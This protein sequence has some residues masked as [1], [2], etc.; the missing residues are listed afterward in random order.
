MK[1]IK[2]AISNFLAVALLSAS[3]ANSVASQ[4]KQSSLITGLTDELVDDKTCQN[5]G[6]ILAYA[7]TKDYALY[8][9]ADLKDV[10]S[11]RYYRSVNKNGTSGVSL[12][13]KTY[14]P[15]QGN[16]FEFYNGDY[17]YLLQIPSKTIQDPV[18]MVEF[19]DGSG[20][21]QKINRFLMSNSLLQRGLNLPIKTDTR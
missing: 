21:E 16:Y 10:A 20:Y 6:G 19:P 9:C 1:L 12:T 5:T 7:E 14:N 17:V 8:V 11:P 18:L 3:L 2:F 13:A 4:V 15:D